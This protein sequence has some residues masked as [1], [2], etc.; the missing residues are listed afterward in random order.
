VDAADCAQ[1]PKTPEKHKNLKT[2]EKS[3]N[4]KIKV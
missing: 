3:E 1:Q 2:L 4:P